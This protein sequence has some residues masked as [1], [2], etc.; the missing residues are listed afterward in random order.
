MEVMI[1]RGSVTAASGA[2][3]GVSAVRAAHEADRSATAAIFHADIPGPPPIEKLP[4]GQLI[5]GLVATTFTALP[6]ERLASVLGSRTRAAAARRWLYGAGPV[7][8]ALPAHVP[9]IQLAA[10][11]AVREAAPMPA[12]RLAA[13]EAAADGTIKYALDLS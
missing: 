4:Y 1:S 5:I 3:A 11:E 10:W 12:W 2:G 6:F 7:P 9:G 13:R 8:P